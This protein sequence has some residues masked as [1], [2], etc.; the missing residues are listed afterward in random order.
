[1]SRGAEVRRQLDSAETLGVV[2]STMKTL[3]LV[4][5]GQYRR[6]VAA[7]DASSVTLDLALQAVLSLY[8]ELLDAAAT[9]SGASLAAVLFG[10]DRG[11]AGPF[12]ERLAQ[13]AADALEGSGAG[14]LSVLAVGRRLESRLR[15]RGLRVDQRVRPPGALDTVELAV[16]EVLAQVDA[17][18]S[19]GRADRL[20]LVHA[21]PTSAAA[22]EVRV[23]QV[24]PLDLAQLREL[25][26]RPWPSR[27]L[28]MAI[29]DAQ[30]LVQGVVR[31]RIASA[32]VRAFAASQASEN[33][34]RLSAM[35]AAERNIEERIASLRSAYNQARQNAITEE[36]L[37][38]QAA[39]AVAGGASRR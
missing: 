5:I 17:W 23:V 29:S 36:L 35:D 21:Q 26:D 4:R 27:R 37:D 2:V 19:A 3:A 22:Y 34:A 1:M 9:P 15:V 18:R 10:T 31:Q 39:Y 28:P 30:A 24:L 32:L 20:L 12:N 14:N 25:R 33:A 16:M 11:L 13:R 7:L 8:P 38:I 6:S